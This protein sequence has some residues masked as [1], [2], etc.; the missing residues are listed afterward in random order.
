MVELCMG[1]KGVF[2][3][4]GLDGLIFQAEY[5]ALRQNYRRECFHP[6]MSTFN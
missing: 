2:Q 1:Q 4:D 5:C 6:L 3:M